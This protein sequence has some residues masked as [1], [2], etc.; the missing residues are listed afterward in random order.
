MNEGCATYVHYRIMN[1]LHEKGLIDRRRDAGVPALAHQR[2][3]PAGLRRSALFRHQ[4]LRARLRDDAA[5]S[6]ASA[7]SRPTRTSTGSPTSPA[8]AIRWHV[9]RDVWANYRDESFILQYPQP[10]ADPRSSGCS[11]W[12]TTPTSRTCESRRST[13]SAAIARS[14]ARWRKQYDIAWTLPDIQVVDVN[15]AGDRRLILHHRALNRVLL[16][17]RDARLR[18]AAPRRSVGLRRA[19]EGGRS[20][21][22][23]G[24]E[25][26]RGD[27]ARRHP[28]ARR[29]VTAT[30]RRCSAPPVRLPTAFRFRLPAACSLARQT[31]GANVRPRRVRAGIAEFHLSSGDF[32]TAPTRPRPCARWSRRCRFPAMHAAPGSLPT[33]SSPSDMRGAS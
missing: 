26:A 28:P 14:S 8:A 31:G 7:P 32:S 23:F 25:G 15:L 19:D 2:G 29:F 27:A 13:T 33:T 4:P 9:L 17:E 24:A 1:R 16:E 10:A 12:S 3:V 21:H 11:T 22:R 30:R 6:S 5:T 18:A 20:G